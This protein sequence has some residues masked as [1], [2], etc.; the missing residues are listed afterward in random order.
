MKK[1]Y[2]I[3][4]VVLTVVYFSSCE[5]E[6]YLSSPNAQLKFSTDTVMFDTVF[7]SIGSTTEHLKVYN[8]YDQKVLISSVRLSGGDNSNFRLNINGVM[9]NEILDLE[10]DAHDSI[11]IFVE[12]TVDPNGQNLPMVVKDSIEFVTNMNFQDIDLLAWG[13]DF[14]LVKD[15]IIKKSTSWTNEKPYLV[16]NYAVVDSTATLTIEPGTK[17]YFHKDAGL[18]VWGKLVANGTFEKPIVM[19]GDRLEDVYADVPDQWNGL[20]LYSGSYKN[21]MNFVEI[22]NANIG[23]Q[24]GTMEH[25][26]YASLKLSNSKIQN[27]AYAGIFAMK[28][29]IKADNCLI[30]NCGFYL[31]ALIGGSYEFHHSTLANYWGKYT[32]KVR[33]SPSLVVSNV[34][35]LSEDNTFTKDLN[36]ATFANC[37]ITGDVNH[38]NELELG[39]SGKAN[40]ACKFDHCILQ[41]ADTFK[42]SNS[43]RFIDILKGKDPKFIDPYE[44]YNFELDTLSPAKD[45]GKVDYARLFP[46]DLKSNNRLNDNGPDL[47]A[48]ERIEKKK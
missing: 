17:V 25:S 6:K 7:T 15:E 35:I 42:T 5:D 1:F 21:E 23:L 3:L 34:L 43:S 29:E 18:Y 11:Y 16:Y 20:L 26:G 46:I 41:V 48:Y 24:V 31:T 4:L 32:N 38:G 28:S 8:P 22:R 13:Q 12:V 30:T 10:I 47:G 40:F 9:A 36:K 27:M 45:A 2:Y 33:T 44:G 14:K 19:Q 37:I 39:Q